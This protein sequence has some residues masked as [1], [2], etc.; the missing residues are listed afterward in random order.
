M[1][2]KGHY[3]TLMLTKDRTQSR[4]KADVLLDWMSAELLTFLSDHILATSLVME[5]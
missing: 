1:E 4:M 3:V 5:F 2:L